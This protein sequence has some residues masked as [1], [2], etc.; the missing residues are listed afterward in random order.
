MQERLIKAIKDGQIGIIGA[1]IR[2]GVD[3][4]EVHGI[5]HETPLMLAVQNNHIEIARI[6]LIFGANIN[7]R[8]AFHTTSLMM[9][10]K[11]GHLNM[12]RML[13]VEKANLNLI[14]RMDRNCL[15]MAAEK[16][17]FHIVQEL[18]NAGANVN[19]R[20]AILG[21]GFNLTLL[22]LAAEAGHSEVVQ[23]LIRAGADIDAKDTNERSALTWAIQK[24]HLEVMQI[25]INAGAFF[26]RRNRFLLRR[27]NEIKHIKVTYLKEIY[28]N[29]LKKETKF[30][31]PIIDIIISYEMSKLDRLMISKTERQAIY[32]YI[33]LSDYLRQKLNPELKRNLD[34]T[35]L[36]PLHRV[37]PTKLLERMQSLIELLNFQPS[38]KVSIFIMSEL[39]QMNGSLLHSLPPRIKNDTS[40]FWRLSSIKKCERNDELRKSYIKFFLSKD[41]IKSSLVLAIGLLILSDV[42]SLPITKSENI[43][44][45]LILLIMASIYTLNKINLHR[46]GFFDIRQRPVL[47]L[48]IS[49]EPPKLQ[50]SVPE[51]KIQLKPTESKYSSS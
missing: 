46:Q 21:G 16:G 7:A 2:D 27:L 32:T 26:D 8:D 29:F 25:L 45:G 23:E 6:L 28:I 18:I 5:F 42:F 12:V 44:I 22:M 49:S 37:P 30:C 50:L 47:P 14:D 48:N 1:L 9:A 10:C 15:M 35:S 31:K 43:V 39:V 19:A 24:N 34:N 3:I 13:L 38:S 20:G 11:L 51:F 41:I 17:H 36:L 33:E 40:F 4:N